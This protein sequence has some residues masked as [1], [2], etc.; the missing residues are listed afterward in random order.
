MVYLPLNHSYSRDIPWPAPL[1]SVSSMEHFRSPLSLSAHSVKTVCRASCNCFFW[2]SQRF[3]SRSWPARSRSRQATLYKSKAPTAS[4]PPL[5][6]DCSEWSEPVPGS[7]LAPLIPSA[8]SRHT[9]LRPTIALQQ[10]PSSIISLNPVKAK[11]LEI[12]GNYRVAMLSGKSVQ[13]L[14]LVTK[15]CETCSTPIFSFFSRLPFNLRS[16]P[17]AQE[18]IECA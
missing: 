8:F 13:V 18:T 9:F 3:H 1:P 4:L 11:C 7:G 2:A 12:I 14:T 16:S 5:R 6:F 15:C 17:A 10:N